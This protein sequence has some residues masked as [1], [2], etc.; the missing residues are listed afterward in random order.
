MLR[1]RFL[2]LFSLAPAAALV[3]AAALKADKPTL[4]T[5]D[6]SDGRP[7][8]VIDNSARPNETMPNRYCEYCG[9]THYMEFS[10]PMMGS[11]IMSIETH[12]PECRFHD[13]HGRKTSCFGVRS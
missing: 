2:R 11:P 1:R 4:A 10:R 9:S 12:S 5:L 8:P 13:R 7:S 3:P 6:I